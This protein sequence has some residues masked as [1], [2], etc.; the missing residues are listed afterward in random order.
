MAGDEPS[1]D[2]RQSE[3]HERFC[4]LYEQLRREVDAKWDRTLPLGDYFVDRW[5]K[6]RRLGFGK[7]TSVYDSSLVIGDVRVGDHTWIGPFTVLEGSGGLTIGSYCSICA[8]V[9]IYTHHTVRWSITGGRGGPQR[10]PTVIGSRCYIGPNSIVAKGVTV[11]DGAVIGAGSL[12]LDDIP[13]G[14]RAFGTPCRVVGKADPK[15]PDRLR[16]EL[17]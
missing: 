15:M 6:A 14:S 12:V 16:D 13:P 17:D 8:G 7:G 1:Q 3:L 2:P 11:G 5:E 9:Q 4:E 10:A